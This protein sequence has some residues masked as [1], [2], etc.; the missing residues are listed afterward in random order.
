MKIG[1]L[2]EAEAALAVYIPLSPHLKRKDTTLRRV[3]PLMKLLDNPQDKLRIIHIAGTSGKT[4]TAYYTAALL[5]AT[6]KK[7]GLAVSPHID[8]I[9]ERIQIN[10]NNISEAEFCSE[11][12]I[13]LDLVKD[14]DPQPS[15]FELVYAFAIWV[16]Q[17]QDVFYAVV[18]T[19]VGGLHDATNIAARTDKVCVITDIGFDHTELLGKTLPAITSQKVGIVHDLNHVFMYKQ[20]DEIMAVVEQGTARHGATLHATAETAERQ[21]YNEDLSTMPDYQQ[22]NWLLAHYV[23]EYLKERDRLPSLTSQALRQTQLV[24]VPGRMDIKQLEGKILIMDGAHN[25]QKVTAFIDSFRRMYPGVKPAILIGLK[26]GKDYEQLTPLLAPLAARVITTA[27]NTSQD[28][29]VVSMDA[30]ILAKSFKDRGVSHVESIP[31]SRAAFRALLAAPEKVCVITGSFYL[32]G[33]IRN[34]EHLA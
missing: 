25:A 4:S 26:D 5:A 29:P 30:G 33:Q 11:L 3:V 18:E 9:T 31:D 23:Y 15:Y 16:L 14:A 1:N 8:T 24:R 17:R 34:N 20:A 21:A 19:G 7:T 13:F 10:G 2:K 6:G 27:F 32:I 28:L 22:R 12:G